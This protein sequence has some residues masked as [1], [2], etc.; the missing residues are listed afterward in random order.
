VPEG[1]MVFKQLSVEENL[2]VGAASVPRKQ[3]LERIQAVYE[4]FP[5][6]QERRSQAAG[7]L[8]GGEQQMVAIGRAL[9]SGP[10]ILL[11]D[12]TS[13]GLAPLII[14]S[15]Y[16]QLDVVNKTL[17]MSMLIVEQN[18][19]MALDFAATAY[20]LDR[21]RITASGTSEQVAASDA[22]KEAYLGSGSSGNQ[23]KAETSA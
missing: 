12:E 4:M 18:A 22:V 19:S 16:R 5:R 13:L 2:R 10:R 3:A 15:I 6:L 17:G 14:E 11:I 23:V 1:R 7:W 21:G 9:V 8:S 20:V